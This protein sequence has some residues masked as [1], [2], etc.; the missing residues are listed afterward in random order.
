MRKVVF[1][2]SASAWVNNNRIAGR[3]EFAI[4]AISSVAFS[5]AIADRFICV[6]SYASV[7]IGK[8]RVAAGVIVPIIDNGRIGV[9][10]TDSDAVKT[11]A[12]KTWL[13]ANPM[14]VYYALDTPTTVQLTPHLPVVHSGI[15]TLTVG[16]DVVPTLSAT[17]KSMD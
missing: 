2:G 14:T 10:D 9:S 1:D 7:D 16:A 4:R 13:A 8:F 15:K 17:V 5:T 11:A 12:F 6:T 3:T